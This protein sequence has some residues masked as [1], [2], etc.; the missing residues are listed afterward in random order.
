MRNMKRIIPAVFTLGAL[1][2][3]SSTNVFAAYDAFLK[4]EGVEGE[5][6]DH[7]REIEIF[8]FSWGASSSSSAVGG[9][10][11]KVSVQDIFVTK[12]L[13]KSSPKLMEACL[14]G[15]TLPRA[16]ITIYRSGERRPFCTIELGNVSISSVQWPFTFCIEDPEEKEEKNTRRPIIIFE[17]SNS[18]AGNNSS[19]SSSSS[20]NT[21]SCPKSVP[22]EE[23][24]LN[25]EKIEVTYHQ[26]DRSGTFIE[27]SS[28]F[29]YDNRITA[30]SR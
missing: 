4:I 27:D 22:T 10:S 1:L 23:L 9:G 11:G 18:A 3:L 12:E 29:S 28:E 21:S 30:T 25:F 16:T 20:S 26:L 17:D 14:T 15:R 8:S 24:S 6:V 7:A 2:L 19:I 5:S 13:D